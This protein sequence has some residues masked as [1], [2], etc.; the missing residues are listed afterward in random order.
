MLSVAERALGEFDGVNVSTALHRIASAQDRSRA[1]LKAR[2]WLVREICGV[3]LL[4][5]PDF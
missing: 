4:K 3:A 1:T 5:L 2:Y